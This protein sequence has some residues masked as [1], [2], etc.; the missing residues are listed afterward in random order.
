M[1]TISFRERMG[2][3]MFQYSLGRILADELKCSLRVCRATHPDINLSEYFEN[4]NLNI[5]RK[6]CSLGPKIN[7][8]H[9]Y[10][11]IIPQFNIPTIVA[12]Q[13]SE[14]NIMGYFEAYGH[15]IPYKEKIK[16]LFKRPLKHTGKLCI[17]LRQG[18]VAQI[19]AAIPEF[20]DYAISIARLYQSMDV[21]LV[22]ESPKHP[23]SIQSFNKLKNTLNAEQPST[24]VSLVSYD[25]SIDAFDHLA[26]ASVLIASSSTFDWWAGFLSGSPT[27]VVLTSRQIYSWRHH[28]KF[29]PHPPN[30]KI[31][32][33][34]HRNYLTT[35]AS[36]AHF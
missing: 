4:V 24:K 3:M 15:L 20:I 7:L 25:K 35:P 22:V 17:H 6:Y 29:F 28:E 31:Y 21:D 18:D 34:D 10:K 1:I 32:S 8:V 11:E 9:T 19:T 14:I 16:D 33:I 12:Q 26:G 30:F 27:Y 13:P 36:F 23:F 5:E 2:N